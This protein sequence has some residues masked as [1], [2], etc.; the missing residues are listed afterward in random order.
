MSGSPREFRGRLGLATQPKV[1]ERSSE[2][3]G[4]VTIR[5]DSNCFT[6]VFSIVRI[7]QICF[8]DREVHFMD[9]F[10]RFLFHK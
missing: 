6:N 5:V 2:F 10:E 3:G 9:Q 8:V 1:E 4:R 7:L